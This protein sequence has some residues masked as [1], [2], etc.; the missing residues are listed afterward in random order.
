MKALIVYDSYFGNTEAIARAIGNELN[1]DLD[2]GIQ[3]AAEVQ[4]AQLS[5]VKLLIVGSP[6]RQFKAS[7]ATNQ[8]LKRIPENALKNV[9]AAAFDTRISTNDIDTRFL[10]WMI[11]LFGYAAEPIS[12]RLKKKGA[13][14][15]SEPEG[16]FVEDTEGPLK[17]GELERA[18]YWANQIVIQLSSLS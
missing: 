1:S 16:F 9:A 15:I 10:R 4:P 11:N 7:A 2:V 8:F 14:I 18:I 3:R 6:T 5:D 13:E 12:D 17:E